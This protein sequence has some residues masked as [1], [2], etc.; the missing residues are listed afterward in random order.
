MIP[1]DESLLSLQNLQMRV[2]AVGKLIQETNKPILQRR[3]DSN[4]KQESALSENGQSKARILHR[5]KHERSRRKGYSNELHDSPKVRNGTLMK[6]IPLDQAS[7]SSRYGVQKKGSNVGSDDV[8][9]E[10]WETADNGK[11][12]QTIGKSRRVS[13]KSRERNQFEIVPSTDSDVEKELG[14]DKLELSTRITEPN[15]EV[16]DIKILERLSSDAKKLESLRIIVHNLRR[17]METNKKSRKAKNID[18]GTVQQQLQEAED[19]IVHLVDLN[20]QLVKN[21]EDCPLDETASPKLRETLKTW[22]IKVMEQA[23]KGSERIELLQMGLQK[24]QYILFKLEDD[25]KNKGRNRFL[26][27]KT[28]ILRDFVD[29]GRKN[30]GRRKKG[31]NCGCFKQSTSRNGNSS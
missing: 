29:N 18:Y 17:I 19:A 25:K 20:G 10:L 7:D 24:T 6:D 14:V 11:G 15:Q 22:R 5:D 23:Q 28:V 12:D 26:R 9:L 2:K 21:I 27:S 1:E 31:P 8:M 3:S 30:S 4:C 13:Y 16:N